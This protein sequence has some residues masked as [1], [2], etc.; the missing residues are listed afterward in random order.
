[1]KTSGEHGPLSQLIR[2]HMGS[3]KLQPQELCLHESADF[4]IY[5]TAV[6]FLFVGLLTVRGTFI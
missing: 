6:S 2:T 3:Q 1:M 4:Y 5:V